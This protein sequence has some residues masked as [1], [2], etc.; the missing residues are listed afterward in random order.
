MK[1]E[2]NVYLN[3][4]DLVIVQDDREYRINRNIWS[5]EKDGVNYPFECAENIHM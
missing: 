4:H 2:I 3:D 5:V 1:N